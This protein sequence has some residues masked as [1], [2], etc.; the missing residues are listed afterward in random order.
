MG[1]PPRMII[2]GFGNPGR[3][4]DGAGVAVA[5]RIEEQLPAGTTVQYDYQLNVED[6]LAV[7]DKDA[8]LFIDASVGE[9]E[10]TRL[11]E[12]TPETVINYSTHAMTPGGILRACEELYGR[13]PPAWLLEIKGHSWELR[14]GLSARTAKNCDAA[15]RITAKIV[16]FIRRNGP[17]AVTSTILK[18]MMQYG[19]EKNSHNR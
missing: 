14:E 13:R 4:D 18:E 11:S 1:D 6:A 8:V 2:C 3:E 9:F 15:L 10:G 17:A 7:V 16:H 5:Q 12:V 19:E